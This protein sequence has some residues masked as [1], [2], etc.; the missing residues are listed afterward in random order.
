MNRTF[1]LLGVGTAVGVLAL[2]ISAT[3][4]TATPTS[5][6][7]SSAYAPYVRVIKSNATGRCLDDSSGYGLRIFPCNNLIYQKF[8]VYNNPNGT[9]F[10]VNRSTGRCVEDAAKGIRAN[11]C[12]GAAN[13]M[14]Y[15]SNWK[16]GGWGISNR[17]TNR[18]VY[19]Y[20][21]GVSILGTE[22]CNWSSRLQSFALL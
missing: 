5:T 15:F 3:S 19:A 20:V 9:H 16:G 22:S 6:T 4:A 11:R 17:S 13:Q 12:T 18:C 14:W 8:D 10:L 21:N 2:G 1:R 7:E